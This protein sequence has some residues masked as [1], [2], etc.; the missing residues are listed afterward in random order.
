MILEDRHT[1]Y[2]KIQT[3]LGNGSTAVNTI[4]KD[5]LNVNKRCACWV[6]HSL[7]EEKK[8]QPMLNGVVSC[9]GNLRMEQ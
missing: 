2:V 1:T 6:P 8:K 7:T 5:Y 3:T 4:L 9:L